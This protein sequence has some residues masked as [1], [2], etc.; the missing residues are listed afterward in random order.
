VAVSSNEIFKIANRESV[1]DYFE[2][3]K[4]TFW[5]DVMSYGTTYLLSLTQENTVH[6]HSLGGG[7]FFFVFLTTAQRGPGPPRS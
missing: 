2:Q 1:T 7:F 3:A 4:C 6:L 5:K